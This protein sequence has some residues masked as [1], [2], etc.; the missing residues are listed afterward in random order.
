MFIFMFGIKVIKDIYFLDLIQ[1]PR[2]F[3]SSLSHLEV[4]TFIMLMKQE[5]LT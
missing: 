3:K 2:F 5:F 1:S 4:K